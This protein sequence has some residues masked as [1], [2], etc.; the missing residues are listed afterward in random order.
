MLEMMYFERKENGYDTDYEEYTEDDLL[1]KER[2][3]NILL[4]GK[5]DILKI[6]N[7]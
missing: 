5:N 7:N 4:H 1:P 2:E 6:I 3:L